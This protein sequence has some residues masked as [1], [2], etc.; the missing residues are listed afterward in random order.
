MSQVMLYAIVDTKPARPLGRGVAGLALRTVRSGGAFVV[1][2]RGP[3]P[4]VTGATVRA[5]DRAIRAVARACP[6]V[7]PMRFGAACEEREVGD[8]LAAFGTSVDAALERVR[9]CV[10]FTWRVDRPRAVPPAKRRSLG[11][12]ARWLAARV[13]RTRVVEV[14]RATAEA[15]SWIRESRVERDDEAK[16][17]RVYHL[18]AKRDARRYR[19]AV[20]A[21]ASSRVALSGPWPPYAFAELP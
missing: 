9:G 1:V 19:A 7:L 4:P 21:A 20:D 13:Q 14:E 18:V 16:R 3:A 15:A 12:G 8:L 11:P 6:A 5:F 17:A 10:Q 2:E